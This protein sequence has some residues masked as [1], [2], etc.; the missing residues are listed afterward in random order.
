MLDRLADLVLARPKTILGLF[1]ALVVA[2]GVYGRDVP[3]ALSPAGYEVGGSE[4]TA[5]Q[6]ALADRFDTGPVNLVVL[7][8][9]GSA[10]GVDDAVVAGEVEALTAEL[11]ATPDLA[12]LT[13]YWAAGDERLRSTDGRHGLITARI[14]ASEDEV[15]DRAET[16]REEL[17]GPRGEL[18]ITV[19]GS[20]VANLEIVEESERDLLRA[21]AIAI[22]VT[23]IIMLLVFRSVIAALLPLVVAAVAV[24]GTAAALKGLSEL[25]LVSIFALNLTTALG[26][27][28]GVD[29]SLFAISRW[30]EERAAGASADDALRTTVRRAGRSIL[31][32]GLTT[33][34]TLAALL[35]FDYPL[36]RSLAVAGFAVV[37][38]ATVGGLVAL[39]AAMALLG[40]HIDRWTVRRSQAEA[41]PVES[42]GWYRLARW[43]MAHP[44]MTIVATVA[45]LLA[46]GSPFLRAEFGIPDDRALP[47]S[48]QARQ[49]ADVIRA[50][51]DSSQFGAMA[52][53]STE[54]I[55]DGELSDHAVEVS[56]IDGV[57]GVETATGIYVDGALVGSSPTPDRFRTTDGGDAWLAVLPAVEPVSTEAEAMVA[58]IR[59]ID[60]P[61]PFLLGGESARQVDNKAEIAS[62]LVPVAIWVFVV[63]SLLLFWSF[64]SIVLPLKAVVLNLL[65]LT[66]S[67]GAIVWIF[68]DGR[69]TGLL[70]FTPTGLTDAQTPILIFCIA[71]GLS[72]DY[73]VFLLSRIKEEWDRTGD[74]RRAVAVGLQRTGGI[75]T[76]AAVLMAAVF[77]AFA[78]GNVTFIQLV[79]IGLALAIIADATLVRSLLVPAFMVVAGRWNWWPSGAALAS[80]ASAADPIDLTAANGSAEDDAAASG[81]RL[82]DGERT[83]DELE[84]VQR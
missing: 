65:S 62:K 43:V 47:T 26:L 35:L 38:L 27:G 84:G 48:T 39:P 30:R 41:R 63:V 13:S 22:P 6:A 53:V 20:S 11:V 42:G 14:V 71:F 60:G 73:E 29:Y 5:A 7:V 83:G 19:G 23:T 9:T 74:T 31:F 10:G 15:Y 4:S 2:G 1:L 24:L 12:D 72:M 52:A 58:G 54:T 55:T 45:V 77:L 80:A 8:D 18:T 82:A 17:S 37:L 51:F 57:A 81:R 68:Q 79:G 56:R 33:A 66:A 64:G 44:G 61:T 78:S 67:F 32:S 40:D 76:A 50:D 69:L 46:L 70:G 21:E 28:M 3:S 36:L 25:T 34:A 16:V 59:A 49:V 75:I